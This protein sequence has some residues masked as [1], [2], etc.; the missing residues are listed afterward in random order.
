MSQ[1]VEF[2]PPVPLVATPR[3]EKKSRPQGGVA[4][5]MV[6]PAALLL[7]TFVI[8]PIALTFALAFTDAKLVSPDGPR[9]TPSWS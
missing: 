7:L 2:H 6:A 9:F 5:W 3:T 4:A 1:S 8:V